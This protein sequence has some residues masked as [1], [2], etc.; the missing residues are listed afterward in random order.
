MIQIFQEL[1]AFQTR[2]CLKRTQ[3]HL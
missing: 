3:Y 1:N 2:H